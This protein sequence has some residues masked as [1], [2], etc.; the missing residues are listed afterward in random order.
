MVREGPVPQPGVERLTPFARHPAVV[1]V[2]PGQHPL[3]VRTA[4][5]WARAVAAPLLYLAYADPSRYVVEEHP[6]GTVTHAAVDPD[7]DDG[8]WEETDAALRK[9]VAVLLRDEPVPWELRYL[10][11]RPDRALTHLARAVDAAVLVV[12]TRTPGAGGRLRELVEGSVAAHLAH[13]QHRPVLTVPL[14][15]VDWS[16]GSAPWGR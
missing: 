5:S 6:D 11:G 7:A 14:R 10:A 9:Q 15:V 2:V 1:G 12:G 4:V 13:H 3:V 16:E 8:S